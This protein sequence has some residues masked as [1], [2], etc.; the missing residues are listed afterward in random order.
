MNWLWVVSV[1]LVL[2]M[3]AKVIIPGGQRI[4][5]SLATVFGILGSVL[6]NAVAGWLRVAD[7]RGIDWT[8]HVLQVIGAVAVVLVG[9]M[10]WSAIRGDRG[11][12]RA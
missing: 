9:D 11:R 2:G 6:G 8:R 4:P 5:T 3:I 10:L 7:P 1:G 12:R